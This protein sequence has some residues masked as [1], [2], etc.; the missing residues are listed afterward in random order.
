V[1]GERVGI[2]VRAHGT[3]VEGVVEQ[4]DAAG[5]T[6]RLEATLDSVAAGQALVLYSGT[7][8]RG[9][10]TITVARRAQA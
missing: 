7:R 8:V 2:Q 4:V 6:V 5:V 1:A 9:A 10:A 3:E